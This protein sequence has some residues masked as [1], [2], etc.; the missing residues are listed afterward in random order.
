MK[1]LCTALPAGGCRALAGLDRVPGFCEDFEVVHRSSAF[2]RMEAVLR[3][4]FSLWIVLA[5]FTTAHADVD[6]TSP[7]AFE[8]MA[9][10]V[11][12]IVALQCVAFEYVPPLSA[13]AKVRFR[14]FDRLKEFP[15]ALLKA[16][17]STGSKDQETALT[18]IQCQA[19]AAR[20]CAFDRGSNDLESATRRVFAPHT[21]AIETAVAKLLDAKEL[22]VRWKAAST[23]VAFQTA[24]A[25]AN[26]ILA[27]RVE[28]EDKEFACKCCEAIGLLHLNTESAINLLIRALGEKNSDVRHS[29][30]NAVC[31]IG[32]QAKATVP[33]LIRLL[34]SGRAARG[35]VE[36]PYVI[37]LPRFANLALL[38]LREIGPDA[39]AAA[40]AIIRLLPKANKEE[41]KEML[42]CLARISPGVKE[43][44]TAIR[45][46]MKNQDAG[47]RITAACALLKLAP[48]DEE[49][50]TF[51]KQ[52][53]SS[54]KKTVRQQAL[55]VCG[56]IGPRSKVVLAALTGLLDDHEEETRILATL[57]LAQAESDA[58]V[59][60]PALEK[61]LTKDA[62]GMKH[63]FV[64]HQAAAQALARIGKTAAPA[65][66]RATAKTSG[67]REFAIRALGSLGKDGTP[68]A[69]QCL[70][71][72]ISNN[73]KNDEGRFFAVIALGRLGPNA[74]GAR[75]ALE[76][77][78]P[79]NFPML[80]GTSWA[81]TE[82][83][84]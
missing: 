29:A 9:E 24:H 63:T 5:S 31:Q 37:N 13:W 47:I 32:P 6:R 36:S 30:A 48:E 58:S 53:L 60:I 20:K 49:A 18:I 59:A 72:I 69:V 21:K 40:P 14:K 66:I 55:E 34:E 35:R 61:L 23:L 45:R 67:G 27:A 12:G 52:A 81:L 2:N 43:N 75:Q 17:H 56:E 33:A 7:S 41:Q 51:V 42:S 25:K 46:A 79:N 57:A 68:E 28:V 77:L 76:K 78:D 38:A 65:L 50:C 3:F 26:S 84:R 1:D 74:R 10:E 80:L 70:V 39:A 22:S 44:L 8:K 73:R 4:S 62:D 83:A 16:L 82:V 64:S 11:G 15:E 19:A 54:Q 71:D